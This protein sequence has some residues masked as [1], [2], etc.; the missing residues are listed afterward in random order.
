MAISFEAD[1]DPQSGRPRVRMNFRNGWS[2]SIVLMS[3]DRTG[4]NFLCASVA[5]CPT[6]EW[7]K[8]KTELLAHEALASELAEMIGQIASREA[9]S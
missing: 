3:P 6:G 2:I 7:G 5:A 4:C 8:G 9:L 1:L